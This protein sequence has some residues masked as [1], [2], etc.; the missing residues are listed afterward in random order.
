[1]SQ[2]KF[3]FEADFFHR[4]CSIGYKS[5]FSSVRRC[6]A[7]AIQLCARE[8]A[9]GPKKTLFFVVCPALEPIIQSADTFNALGCVHFDNVSRAR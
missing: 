4:N 7:G 9:R 2:R 5:Y 8:T 6:K 3:C 1:M